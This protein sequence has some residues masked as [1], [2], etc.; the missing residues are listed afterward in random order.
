MYQKQPKVI[1][2]KNLK[3]AANLKAIA[4]RQLTRKSMRLRNLPPMMRRAE[5]PAL[6]SPSKEAAEA[7]AHSL[8]TA[9]TRKAVPASSLGLLFLAMS[10][11]V[12][13]F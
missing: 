11:F 13:K 6:R 1:A 10:Y 5:A 12:R 4:A 8:L 3:N 7:V 9:A 2:A